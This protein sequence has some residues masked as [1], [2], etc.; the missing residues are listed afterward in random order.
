MLCG[1]R[2]RLPKPIKAE[3]HPMPLAKINQRWA[4]DLVKMSRSYKGN[5]WILTFT[6]YCTRYVAAFPI[7]DAKSSTIAKVFV[8]NICFKF[9][10][11]REMVSDLGANLVSGIMSEVCRLLKVK[12]L[13]SSPYHPQFNGVLERWHATLATTLSMYVNDRHDDWDEYIAAACFAYNSSVCLE[14]TSYSPF[15][16]MFGREPVMPLDTVLP[17]N[18][19][20]EDDT[21]ETFLHRLITCREVAS[22][23]LLEK[24]QKMKAKYDKSKN[25]PKV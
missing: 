2:K 24:Q 7:K 22:S 3:L 17:V 12:R 16:L 13:T 6:E 8:D 18:D 11:P 25:D 15:F 20:T 14:S 4:V 9:G 19:A 23:Y 1:S 21:L 10:L 5:E